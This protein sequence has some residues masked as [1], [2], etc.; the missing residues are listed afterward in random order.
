MLQVD[1]ACARPQ[2][3]AMPTFL[4]SRGS[5]RMTRHQGILPN[6]QISQERSDMKMSEKTMQVRSTVAS[7][8]SLA[9]PCHHR[10]HCLEIPY[11]SNLSSVVVK[12]KIGNH[13][14]SRIHQKCKLQNWRFISA[15]PFDPLNRNTEQLNHRNLVTWSACRILYTVSCRHAVELPHT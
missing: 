7:C 1:V 2:T 15:L 11:L 4:A 10:R 3:P 6:P 9:T 5:T 13:R 14:Q 12:P 8:M